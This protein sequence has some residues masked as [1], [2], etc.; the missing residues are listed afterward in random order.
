MRFTPLLLLLAGC[1]S[2][3]EEIPV[4]A[5]ARLVHEAAIVVDTHSDTS[6]RLLE[7]GVDMGKRSKEGHMDLPRMK[8]GGVD[9]Q[10]FASWV[11][12]KK[13]AAKGEGW[14]RAVAMAE[15]VKAQVAKYP[16]RMALA[17]TAAEARRAVAEGKVAAVLCVEGGHAIDD[18]LDVLRKM[19]A[20]GFRYLTLT[21]MNNNGWADGSGDTPRH[22]GLSD[23]GR[24]VVREMNRIGM[25]V[26]VSH[27]SE[28]TFWDVLETTTVPVLA[29][30]SSCR[31]LAD[32]HRNLTDDQLRALAKNG[33][34][35][36]INFYSGY[37]DAGYE[38]RSE[39][40]RKEMYAKLRK[41]DEA[42]RRDPKQATLEKARIRREYG[43]KVKR[44]SLDLIV[45]HIVH[46][47][48]IAGVDHVGLGSDFDGVFSL[49]EGLDDCAD[50]PKI[51]QKLLDRGWSAEDVT[52]VLGGNTLRL[53]EQAVD[54]KV[55][56]GAK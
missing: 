24:E 12:P 7:R 49:P 13:Y 46:A 11:D 16:D 52:K 48:K 51:T 35:A 55:G 5:K 54:A 19:H 39:S 31:A 42:N 22:H 29:S 40:A 33:G 43:G 3:P 23:F 25:I 44:P 1:T 2:L 32:H 18:D 45:D 10:F 4:S 34:V 26:D 56:P 50:L 8:E 14:K 17:T 38:A 36:C 47:A 30:H 9:V 41:V 21:W 28:E 15:A 37:L 6:E 53:M 20:Y 27:A